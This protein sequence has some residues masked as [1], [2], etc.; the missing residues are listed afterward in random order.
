[1]KNRNEYTA[2]GIKYQPLSLAHGYPDFLG[3]KHIT[4]ALINVA[5]NSDYMLNQYT[6]GFVSENQTLYTTQIYLFRFLNSCNLNLK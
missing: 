1:M 2:L 3:P 6:R 5:S 4:D